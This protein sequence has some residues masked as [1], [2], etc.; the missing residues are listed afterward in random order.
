[1][2]VLDDYSFAFAEAMN[3]CKNLSRL[4]SKITDPKIE[5]EVEVSIREILRKHDIDVVNMATGRYLEL[6]EVYRDLDIKFDQYPGSV[7]LAKVE[8]LI[9]DMD[10]F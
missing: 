2:E 10:K 4:V 7:K 8:R 1:M 6:H 5:Y 3:K 9:K